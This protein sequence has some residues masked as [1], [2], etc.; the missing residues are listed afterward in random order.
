MCENSKMRP[1]ESIP[2]VGGGKIKENRGGGDTRNFENVTV[3]SQYNSNM[4]TKI[5][6]KN[7]NMPHTIY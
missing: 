1:G 6:N 4:I 3:Y 2:R 5:E 7:K